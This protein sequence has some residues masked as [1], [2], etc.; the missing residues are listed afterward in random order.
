MVAFIKGKAGVPE[1][2]WGKAV[3]ETE[4][5]VAQMD[6]DKANGWSRASFQPKTRAEAIAWLRR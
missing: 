1:R 3:A 6:A 4:K 2:F 5:E